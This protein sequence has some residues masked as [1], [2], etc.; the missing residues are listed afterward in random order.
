MVEFVKVVNY[1]YFPLKINTSAENKWILIFRSA[2]SMA[3][4]F[5]T[6][7]FHFSRLFA[8]ICMLRRSDT[9]LLHTAGKIAFMERRCI[10]PTVR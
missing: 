10:K 8:P 1:L 9:G 4:V 6:G 2:E 7:L 3:A 5:T